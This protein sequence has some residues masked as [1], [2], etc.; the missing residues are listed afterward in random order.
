MFNR[1]REIEFNFFTAWAICMKLWKLVHHAPGDKTLPRIFQFFPMD[2]VL[3]F[4]NRTN[5]VKS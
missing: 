1:A 3:D 2:L 4:Q 5:M